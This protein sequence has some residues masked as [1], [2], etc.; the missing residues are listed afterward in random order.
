MNIWMN[1]WIG[2][3]GK[4]NKVYTS[5]LLK[6]VDVKKKK[7]LQITGLVLLKSDMSLMLLELSVF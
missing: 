1:E 3:Y 7:S 5:Y 2:L 6:E 4:R